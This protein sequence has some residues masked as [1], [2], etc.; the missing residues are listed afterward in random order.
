[1]AG[2]VAGV[3][4]ENVVIEPGP[5]PGPVDVEPVCTVP[6]EPD[7][8]LPPPIC[9]VPI[10]PEASLP[11]PPVPP[12]V[13]GTLV[14]PS[15]TGPCESCTLGLVEIGADWAVKAEFDAV[16]PP[17]TCAVPTELP[18]WFPPLLPT[19]TGRLAIASPNGVPA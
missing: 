13:T 5:L 9:T 15:P 3:A 17:P 14:E 19:A 1:A 12:T 6:V 10:E 2:V 7:A 11:P 18:A 4:A 16:L 8:E